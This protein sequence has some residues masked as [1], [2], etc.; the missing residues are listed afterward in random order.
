MSLRI[1]LS[2][3]A[4]AAAPAALAAEPTTAKAA[5]TETPAA[6]NAAPASAVASADQSGEKKICKRAG[7]TGSRT[8]NNKKVCLTKKQW[9]DLEKAGY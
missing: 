8:D 2:V 5:A 7:S 1:V 6:S 4:L 3:L 9:K